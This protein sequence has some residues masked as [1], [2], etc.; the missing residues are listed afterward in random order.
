MC[1]ISANAY[2][3]AGRHGMFDYNVDIYSFGRQQCPDR[4]RGTNEGESSLMISSD[5]TLP[6][7]IRVRIAVSKSP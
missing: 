3:I 1:Y 5:H 6:I 2:R 7:S 4:D